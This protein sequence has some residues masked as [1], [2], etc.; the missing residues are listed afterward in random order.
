MVGVTD[1]VNVG[2]YLRVM[3]LEQLKRFGLV[4]KRPKLRWRDF[5]LNGDLLGSSFGFSGEDSLD[6]DRKD[7]LEGE[8]VAAA[9]RC[10]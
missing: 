7:I 8:L 6:Q 5:R 1:D 10:A 9:V 3:S 2:D 4:N